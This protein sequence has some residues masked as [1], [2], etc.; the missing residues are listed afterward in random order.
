MNPT[1]Y[2]NYPW[3]EKKLNFKSRRQ[4]NSNMIKA[5]QIVAGSLYFLLAQTLVWF[6]NNSQ[7]AWDWWKDKPITTCL[8]YAFPA[9]LFFWYGSKYSYAG[10]G[11]A[12]GSRLLGFGLSYLTFPVL[13]YIFLH[14]SMFT[15][16]T[17]SCVFLSVCII[18]IQVFW[19]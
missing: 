3:R 16:K 10:L 11:D 13:T 2:N 1:P 17:L 4:Y 14:E 9:S 19:R 5:E 18:M 8:I 12:W 6:M 7:F 15:P